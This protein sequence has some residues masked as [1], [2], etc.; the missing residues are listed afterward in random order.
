MIINEYI[1][2]AAVWFQDG[3]KHIHQPINIDVG[4]VVTGR[5]HHNC[6][7][8]VSILKNEDYRVSDYGNNMQGFLTNK[9]RFVNRKEAAIIAYDAK[10]IDKPTEVLFSEDIY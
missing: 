9:N 4:F 10:Q 2:S 7:I 8:S 6:F 3:N 1:I 5:R